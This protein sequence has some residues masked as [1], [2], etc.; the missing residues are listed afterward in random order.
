[1][2]RLSTLLIAMVIMALVACEEET[3]VNRPTSA[4][5]RSSMEDDV[6]MNQ[7]TVISGFGH[8]GSRCSKIDTTNRFSYGPCQTFKNI[9]STFLPTRVNINF[10]TLFKKTGITTNLVIS[11]DNNGKN[12]FWAGLDLKDQ[13]KKADEWTNIN[14]AYTLPADIKPDD[15][16]S[17]YVWNPNNNIA[18]VD[19]FDVEFQK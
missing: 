12:I 18:F 1:M 2:K 17:I 15:R 3:P 4:K 16:I 10:W 7:H 11:I 9:D 5:M 6:W 14:A 8:T 13:V 19:D